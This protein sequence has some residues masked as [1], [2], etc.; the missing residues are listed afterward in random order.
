M[1]NRVEKR[2]PDLV[3]ETCCMIFSRGM[4]RKKESIS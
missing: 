4:K 1:D 2:N 3:A